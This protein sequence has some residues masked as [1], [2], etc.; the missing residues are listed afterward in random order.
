MTG[1]RPDGSPQRRPRPDG[2][3]WRLSVAGPIVSRPCSASVE[4]P[5]R[6]RDATR[7]RRPPRVPPP[8]QAPPRPAGGDRPR[9]AGAQG[10]AG[11]TR[12]R[13]AGP[14]GRTTTRSPGSSSSS[15]RTRGRSS[16]PRRGWPSSRTSSSAS[17]SRR[18]TTRSSPRSRRRRPR[19]RD[20][21]D[22]I[23]T[24][25]TEIEE[26]TAAIPAVEK[27]WADAQAE[28][29][30]YK[31]EAAERL[32]RLLA[33]QAAT[34][35]ELAEAETEA[36]AG[37]EGA[38]RPAGEGL[39]AGRRWRRWSGKVVPAVPDGDHRAA[40]AEPAGRGVPGRVR[41]CGEGC[42]WRRGRA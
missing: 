22:A 16:R 31:Q 33:D 4:C 23:L 42:T 30:Q 6:S 21:E 26:R 9:P 11:R 35:A 34:Q 29:E 41:T 17:A 28:F 14:Q 27:K 38:V 39:R 24:T 8:P 19:R 2:V 25:M 1:E 36:A 12:R 37:G 5:Q 15:G 18:S 40:A 7:H 32:E 3:R 10:P 20:L 13:G